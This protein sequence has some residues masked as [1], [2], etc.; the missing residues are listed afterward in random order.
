[1]NLNKLKERG[2]LRSLNTR[3]L[4]LCLLLEWW[5]NRL[6]LEVCGSGPAIL[7]DWGSIFIDSNRTA[8]ISSHP[9]CLHCSVGCHIT[10]RCFC[11]CHIKTEY[12]QTAA[13]RV[14]YFFST[15]GRVSFY[16][17]RGGWL[18]DCRGLSFIKAFDMT[19]SWLRWQGKEEGG[20]MCGRED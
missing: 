16:F 8:H 7:Q 2:P 3:C 15:L 6:L 19:R 9:S 11:G 13:F 5:N 18:W 20:D 4:C 10:A 17:H 12:K 1:M 14:Y